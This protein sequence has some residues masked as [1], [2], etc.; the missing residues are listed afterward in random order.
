MFLLVRKESSYGGNT[1]EHKVLGKKGLKKKEIKE[2]K[3]GL[4][5]RFVYLLFLSLFS[6]LL[7]VVS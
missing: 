4:S 5:L 2:E 7:M 6:S 3:M 1:L